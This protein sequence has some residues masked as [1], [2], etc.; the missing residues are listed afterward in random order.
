MILLYIFL[1]TAV[2]CGIVL[3]A[4]YIC[5]RLAFFSKPRVPLGDGEYDIPTGKGYDEL[6]DQMI[7]WVDTKRSLP[8][9]EITVT[10]F[11]GLTLRGKYYE[12]TPG[13]PV[14]LL[15][16]GYRGS[17]ERDLSGAIERCFSIG[18]SALLVDQ[19]GAGSSD[20]SVISFGINECRDCLTWIDRAIERFGDDVTLII[21]GVSMG[22]ATVTMAS[23]EKLPENVKYVIADCGYTSP[24]EIIIKV[25]RDLGL[26]P[27]LVYPFIRLGGRLFGH[28][29]IEDNSPIKAVKNS[30]IP[31]F[32]IHGDA[33]DFVPCHMSEKLAA[34]CVAP[35]TFVSVNGAVHGLAFPA[36]KELYIRSLRDFERENSIFDKI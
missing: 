2:I 13:A 4:S 17:A 20:G 19:R 7:A 8:Y 36:D 23:A 16:H 21:A 15:F 35:N 6:R 14:E 5:Y 3:T 29:D 27:W 22:A 18:R 1:A 24:R 32:F 10:S 33:D 28:F 26:S 9:E 12:F 34:E 11:D 25:I 30:R 31:V